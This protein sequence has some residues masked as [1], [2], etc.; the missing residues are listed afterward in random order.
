MQ[1]ILIGNPAGLWA[2]LALPVIVL[3][4]CLHQ[5]A[6][7]L[8]V[9]TLFLLEHVAPESASGSRVE[10]FRQSVPFWMQIVAALLIAWMLTAPRWV[11]RD[12][13]QD[14]VV[15]FDSSASMAAFKTEAKSALARVLS[16]WERLAATT[17]WHLL[18]ADLRRPVL[19]TGRMK[20]DLWK[21]YDAWEP[22]GAA[23]DPSAAIAAGQGLRQDGKGCVIYLTDHA[24]E[25]AGE[26]AVLSVGKPLENVGFCGLEVKR[27]DGRIKWKAL[28]RNT[29]AVSQSR[30]WQVEW[31]GQKGKIESPGKS[32]LTIEPGKTLSLQGELPPNV[33]RAELVM[34]SD[35]F[36]LDD[37]LPMI[38]PIDDVLM[39]TNQVPGAAGE[40]LGKMIAADS[41]VQL[42]KTGAVTVAEIG[43]QVATDSILTAPPAADDA[44]LD[45]EPVAAENHALVRDL[46][47][48]GLMTVKPQPAPLLE[49]D[50]PLLWRGGK[51]LAYERRTN[52]ADGK[53]VTQLFLN[54]DMAKSNASRTP[55]V[56]VLLHRW[57]AERRRARVGER[58]GNFE[59]GQRLEVPLPTSTA[60]GGAN[61]V[62]GQ[63]SLPWTGSVPEPPG[64]FEVHAEGRRLVV[65]A[66]SFADAREADFSQCGPKDTTDAFA[67]E[68]TMSNTEGDQL[69]PVWTLVVLG[70]CLTAWGWG[71]SR[72]V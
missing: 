47:W 35:I 53:P 4:H 23:L 18:S 14:V 37:R 59:T 44:L 58:V 45:A 42:A 50:T 65:G 8:R 67:T 30:S 43:T 25:M 72:R 6:R 46:D 34:E 26:V 61:L 5:R 54:W 68:A 17:R 49:A 51:P 16:R 40:V 9:S 52:N 13:A 33:E 36:A 11:R 27:E 31:R 69:G 3:I 10:L 57:L 19:Y 12:S 38:N 63:Q 15:V 70:C 56:V 28:A 64:F 32:D 48:S 20:A 7:L 71:T 22:L 41:A 21:A 62:I 2:L 60:I 66:A 55:A 1:S 39:V 24:E 29:G